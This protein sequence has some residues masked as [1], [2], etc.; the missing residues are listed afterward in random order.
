MLD[1]NAMKNTTEWLL[2]FW[3]NIH[4]VQ[5]EVLT[6]VTMKSINTFVSHNTSIVSRDRNYFEIY[7]W[8][9]AKNKITCKTN[10]GSWRVA[11][12]IFSDRHTHE[13]LRRSK[14]NRKRHHFLLSLCGADIVCD[15]CQ[16]DEGFYVFMQYPV[17]EHQFN[18]HTQSHLNWH[19]LSH[20]VVIF[21][22]IILRSK[23]L[24]SQQFVG[25]SFVITCTLLQV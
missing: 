16:A 5:L 9:S 1:K 11:D 3:N 8:Q 25:L 12:C 22:K 24:R 23:I 14:Q 20:L 2:C 7:I 13:H 15:C 4:R 21:I 19:S 10:I 17:H 18:S 6:A